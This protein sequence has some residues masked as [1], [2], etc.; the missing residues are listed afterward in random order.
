[1]QKNS[2]PSIGI[3]GRGNFAKL[4][5][6]LFEPYSSSIKMIGRDSSEADRESVFK[7]DIIFLSV[8]LDAYEKV[9]NDL[10][11]SL[12]PESLVVDV[13]SIKVKPSRIIKNILP[14]HNN[15]LLTHPLFGPQS[16]RD[17]TKGLRL[18]VCESNGDLS[19]DLLKFC[20]NNLDLEIIKM[21]PED[22]DKA[23]AYTHALTFFI[24]EALR[25]FELEKHGITT[26]SFS[27]LLNLSKVSSIESKELLRSI[28]QDNP[29]AQEVR[30]TFAKQVD[31]LRDRL[32]KI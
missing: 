30:D 19:K 17:S 9:L 23:M 13:C 24:S 31:N 5:A 27:K 1:M 21:T 26:P 20:E 8:T 32:D 12:K 3:I 25:P 15:I 14:N 11:K 10:K 2:K 4:L 7:S 16:A 29:F 6:D 28:H 22:H 18:I